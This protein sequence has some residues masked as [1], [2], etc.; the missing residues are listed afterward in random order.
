MV[1][2]YGFIQMVSYYG[3]IWFIYLISILKDSFH[4]ERNVHNTSINLKVE[5]FI[6]IDTV[7]STF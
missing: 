2:Y 4:T 3:F 7:R 1:S 5:I 6:V